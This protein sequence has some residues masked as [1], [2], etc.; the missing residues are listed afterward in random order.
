MAER[1]LLS[2]ITDAKQKSKVCTQEK[3][4]KEEEH[5]KFR[6]DDAFSLWVSMT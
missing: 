4:G 5:T 3:E 1:K 2:K 6:T